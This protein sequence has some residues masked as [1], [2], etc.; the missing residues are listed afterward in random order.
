MFAVELKPPSVV[1]HTPSCGLSSHIISPIGGY[2]SP[3]LAFE[4]LHWHGIL[5]GT[6]FC[7]GF[8]DTVNFESARKVRN[9]CRFFIKQLTKNIETSLYYD[10][11][12]MFML[13][14]DSF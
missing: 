4:S 6:G 13:D 9:K 14:C 3:R 8:V 5:S 10:S 7:I 2:T 11:F 1:S 12:K